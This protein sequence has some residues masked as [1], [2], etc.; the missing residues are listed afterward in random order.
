MILFSAV[1][2]AVL[3]TGEANRNHKRRCMQSAQGLHLAPTAVEDLRIALFITTHLSREHEQFLDKCWPSIISKSPLLQHAEVIFLTAR[4]PPEGLLQR[5]FPGKIV[6]VEHY[7][8]PGYEEGAMLAMEIATKGRWFDGYDWVIR[9]NPDVLVLEDAFII[10]N[11]LDSN[12]TGIFADCT[13]RANKCD[14]KCERSRINTD[15]FAARGS[16]V[17]PAWFTELPKQ[18]DNAENQA[19]AAFQSIV[20]RG[21]DRWIKG[22]QQ[23]NLCRVRGPGVPVLH[24]HEVVTK[25]PLAP[26]EPK[27]RGR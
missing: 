13:D 15:F 12:V 26:G 17:G 14:K 7:D 10:K 19:T 5:V 18:F 2:L 4:S 25:C 22:T 8:N 21:E 27:E 9:L 16:A 3:A 1:F 6:R 24:D 11:M 23:R 20:K